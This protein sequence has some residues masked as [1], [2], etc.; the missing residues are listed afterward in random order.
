MIEVLTMKGN[1]QFCIFEATH[2]NVITL[3]HSYQKYMFATKFSINIRIYTFISVAT[4]ILTFCDS[5]FK[6]FVTFVSMVTT[7]PSN[8]ARY[9]QPLYFTFK[10]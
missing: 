2:Q 10:F 8:Q 9:V 6:C 7:K 5:S 1:V 4:G 3:N